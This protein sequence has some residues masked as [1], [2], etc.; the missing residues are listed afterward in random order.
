VEVGE[1]TR[2]ST[3]SSGRVRKWVVVGSF[4]FTGVII[5]IALAYFHILLTANIPILGRH[6]TPRLFP[7][8]QLCKQECEFD[9]FSIYEGGK[10]GFIDSS[11]NLLINFQF[12]GGAR[13]SQGRRKMGFH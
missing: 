13:K 8:C 11:G 4:V 3:T 10:W 9:K 5:C 7:V 2:N 6:G 1:S 12:F